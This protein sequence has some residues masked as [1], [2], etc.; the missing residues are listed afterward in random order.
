MEE[1][2]YYTTK[3][4]L[5]KN[6][7]KALWKSLNQ[8][9]GKS[10]SKT[11][12]I[13]ELLVEK[14]TMTESKQIADYMNEYF[15]DIAKQLRCSQ[16]VE[17]KPLFQKEIFDKTFR[18]DEIT[19][20]EV[21]KEVKLLKNGKSSYDH[22]P[23]KV[24]KECSSCVY[25]HLCKLYN[26]SVM[27]GD[28]P[29]ALKKS[30]I[31][32]IYKTGKR[33]EPGNYRP[34]SL[35]SY[36]DKIF[37]KLMHKR[38]NTFFEKLKVYNIRQYGFRKNHDTNLALLNIVN[39][40]FDDYSK[41]KY[42]IGL[43]LDISKAFDTVD[44]EILLRILYQNGIRGFMHDWIK[45]FIVNRRQN[46]MINGELSTT[47]MNKTGVPQGS[48]LGPLLF[49]MYIN[50][51]SHFIDDVEINLHNDD[52]SIFISEE[53]LEKVRIKAELVLKRIKRY[54]NYKKLAI[55]TS[56]TEF[57]L[58]T[59]QKDRIT[60]PQLN[61]CLSDRPITQV[62]HTKFLGVHIDDK[63]KF[64]VHTD[65]LVNKL[66][67]YIP[68]YY[69]LRELVPLKILVMLHEQL[70]LSSVRYCLMIYGSANKSVKR[71]LARLL[72][73]LIKIL[74]RKEK[75]TCRY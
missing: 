32:P 53:S 75:N 16:V 1:R 15:T 56:K 66:K 42:I 30:K 52:T 48:T 21:I 73:T 54:M 19:L 68:L 74:Y 67:K 35:L 72:K 43:N 3:L 69:R 55:N 12:H 40:L 41:N 57:I 61:L 64:D 23:A 45:S 10:M 59:P 6:D 62:K 11:S 31:I 33:N 13:K 8:I 20:E 5:V 29:I 14:Q 44:H 24:F 65:H 18:F 9:R 50:D 49:I 58:L 71:R 28:F 63:L 25:E 26:H 38:I 17:D 36:V 51:I 27:S 2:K 22:I 7:T 70:C 46:T 39:K 37:E 60:K 47:L 4:E 34:I